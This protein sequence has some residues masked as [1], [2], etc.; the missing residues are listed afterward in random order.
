M[1]VAAVSKQEDADA[2]VDALKKKEYPAFV[3]RKRR[4]TS[5]FA[6]SWAIRHQRSGGDANTPVGD[7]YN[8]I[9]KNTFKPCFLGRGSGPP[10][11][12]RFLGTLSALLAS[13]SARNDE[14]RAEY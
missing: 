8:P 12:S 3:A 13:A 7:G 14:V 9:V 4:P 5:Y 11:K 6:C 2:L 10:Q 1:Q